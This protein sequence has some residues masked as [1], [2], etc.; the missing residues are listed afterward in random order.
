MSDS[1][2][3]ELARPAAPDGEGATGDAATIHRGGA[4]SVEAQEVVIR[5]GG[6]RSVVARDVTIRQGGAVRVEAER[7]A[8]T[9]GGVV[10]A[11][12]K[13]LDVSIHAV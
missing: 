10:L 7:V 5:Q 9:Q 11:L 8:V 6:A 12:T 2:E 3:R 1:G 13:A 4:D